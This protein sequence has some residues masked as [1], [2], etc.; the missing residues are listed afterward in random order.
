MIIWITGNSGAGKT[1]LAHKIKKQVPGALLI[2]GD[3]VRGKENNWDFSKEARWEH[4]IK[5][6]HLA[7]ERNGDAE[8]VI[9]SVI[10]PYK[11]L[12][13]KIKGI[14]DPLFIYL[15]GGRPSSN[16][17]PYELPDGLLDFNIKL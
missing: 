12:R 9:V 14:C 4:N 15:P 17:Y 11:V 6:A 13:D 10:A 1:T 5:V 7:A 8:L 16:T 2:D 3:D